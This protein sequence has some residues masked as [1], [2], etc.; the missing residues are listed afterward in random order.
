LDVVE[1]CGLTAALSFFANDRAK[2]GQTDLSVR[3]TRIVRYAF[4]N[5]P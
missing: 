2:R 4:E 5:L 1:R 3:L